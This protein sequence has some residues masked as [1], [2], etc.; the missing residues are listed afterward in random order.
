M[1]ALGLLDFYEQLHQDDPA[2]PDRSKVK[3]ENREPKQGPLEPSTQRAV[4]SNNTSG[5]PGVHRKR[6]KW[7][8][9]ITFEKV[10]YQL[11]SHESIKKSDCHKTGS[12]KEIAG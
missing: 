9:K 11:G 1:D 3:Q 6:E 7:A 5:Y 2:L 8:A 4:R 12:G 10:T